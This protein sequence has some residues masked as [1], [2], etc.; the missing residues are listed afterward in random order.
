MELALDEVNQSGG[1]NGKKLE[2][3]FEDRGTSAQKAVVAFNKLAKI[4]RVDAIV[5][6]I[7]SFVTTEQLRGDNN[8]CRGD[9]ARQR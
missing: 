2:V 8:H 1:I 7:F 4:D 5:G 3:L 6:D 9:A